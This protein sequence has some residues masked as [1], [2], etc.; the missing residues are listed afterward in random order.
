MLLSV[1]A[2]CGVLGGACPD[3]PASAMPRLTSLPRSAVA[4]DSVRIEYLCGNQF[5]VWHYDTTSVY[6]S[7]DVAES[8]D[9]AAHGWLPG[10]PA[11]LPYVSLILT[12]LQK[13]T[14]RLHARGRVIGTAANGGKACPPNLIEMLDSVM[15]AAWRKLS[16]NEKVAALL[17]FAAVMD[18]PE[19]R[20]GPLGPLTGRARILYDSLVTA[21]EAMLDSASANLGYERV[22]C[23]FNRA[24]NTYGGDSLVRIATAAER[25]VR[26]RHTR[27]EIETG[28]KGIAFAHDFA[29]DAHCVRIDSLWYARAAKLRK[30][31]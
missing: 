5:Q 13:G 30:G 11:R 3:R 4:A 22:S 20:Y 15:P 31:R 10:R 23:L 1:L 7:W 27:T 21:E 14:M 19:V 16:D 12:T 6:V 29:D 24:W 26:A 9:T 2:L 28:R 8:A 25:A 18:D 17:T